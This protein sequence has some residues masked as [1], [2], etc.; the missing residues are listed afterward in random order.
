MNHCEF[1][2]FTR[3]GIVVLMVDLLK[4]GAYLELL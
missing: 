3:K 4:G 1:T 2:L